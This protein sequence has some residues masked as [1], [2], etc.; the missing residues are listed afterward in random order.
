M[1]ICYGNTHLTNVEIIMKA[2]LVS[3]EALCGEVLIYNYGLMFVVLV[4]GFK[5][6]P[7]SLHAFSCL[8]FIMHVQCA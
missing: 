3:L 1:L 7:P 4:F 5:G 6:S 2:F 8:Q